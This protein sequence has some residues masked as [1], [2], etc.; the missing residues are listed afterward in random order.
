MRVCVF[1]GSNTGKH[2]A[3]AAAAH[4]LGEELVRRGTGLVYG[5]GDVG[6]MGI[7][8][9]TVLA[10]GGEVIGVIP[11]HLVNKEV[12]HKSL[13]ELRVVNT[14]H[15][16]KALMADLSEAFIA[17]PGG[18]GTYD[19]FCEVLTWAQLGLHSKPC[20]LLNV[21]GFYDALLAQFDRA[22][23]E[24]F[25]RPDH[26][27]MLVVDDDPGALL[28]RLARYEAPVVAKWIRREDV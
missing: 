1:C 20:G 6:L 13:S 28:N 27:A 24:G 3:Y 21:R 25:V 12:A 4:A 2:P 7:V 18:Y 16:R 5:G 11:I 19:E 26:R 22:T 10:A 14:M 9:D 23:E 15:E 8:A 17:L